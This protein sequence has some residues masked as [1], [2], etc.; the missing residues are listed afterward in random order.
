MSDQHSTWETELRQEVEQHEFD[1]DPSAWLAMEQLLDAGVPAAA[2]TANAS[3]TST[4]LQWSML[5]ITGSALVLFL[6]H[7]YSVIE[8]PQEVPQEQELIL[9][10]KPPETAVP[11]PT[12]IAPD[13]NEIESGELI[14]PPSREVERLDP[15]IT[16]WKEVERLPSRENAYSSSLLPSVE[17][18]LLPDSLTA[19]DVLP[20][21]ELPSRKRNRKKLFPDVLKQN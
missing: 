20:E 2:S 14:I 11:I 16:H 10:E 8:P 17:I 21:V 19:R 3:N 6:W 12:T 4:W 9:P 5:V 1:Y 13:E 18:E 15:L 7:S